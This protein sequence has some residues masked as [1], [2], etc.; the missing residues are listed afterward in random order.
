MKIFLERFV[1]QAQICS[2]VR[3]TLGSSGPYLSWQQVLHDPRGRQLF[4]HQ[5]HYLG[6]VTGKAHFVHQPQFGPWKVVHCSWCPDFVLEAVE[7]ATA[8][9]TDFSAEISRAISSLTKLEIG[10]S[11]H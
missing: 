3:K 6:T 4:F 9:D 2:A 8:P 11:T 5:T 7:P 1:H 10:V